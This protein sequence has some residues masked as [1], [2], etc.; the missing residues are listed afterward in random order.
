VPLGDVDL[1]AADL[2]VSTLPGGADAVPPVPARVAGTPLLDVAYSP[3]PTAIGARWLAAGG[4]LR[5]GLDMLVEQ[6]VLQVRV[7][8]DADPDVPMPHEDAVRAAM[9]SAVGR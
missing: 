1:A 2:V 6:A 5:H 9:R 3:W 7:F 8:T 4:V